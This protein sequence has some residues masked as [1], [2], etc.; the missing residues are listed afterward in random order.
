MLSRRSF[1]QLVGASVAA[2]T[3]RPN[4]SLFA[5]ED[6]FY[7]GR[8]LT[9]LP[10]YYSRNLNAKPTANLWPDAITPIL[11]HD[12]EWYQVPSGWVRREGLQPILP[13]DAKAYE[14][15]GAV[16]F[17]AEVAAPVAPVRAFCAA[18]APLVARIGHGGV[19]RVID[20][21]PGEPNGWYGI[22]DQQGEL[23]GWTQGVFWRP[24]NAEKNIGDDHR[25]S[26]DRERGLMSAYEGTKVVLEVPFS[27]GSGLQ[28]GNFATQYGVIGGVSW[29]A[30]KRYEGIGWQTLF[31]E[32]QMIG[33]VYWHNQ[34][35]H[36]IH[37]GPAVQTTPL[38][39]RWLYG[40]LGE[41]AHIVVK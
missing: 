4:F 35:G 10:I 25:L 14:F 24:V 5:A 23:L 36:P 1:L 22:A 21:L 34:F 6:K 32:G 3:L 30:N 33:G 18:D 20:A 19:S 17:W 9:T 41:E 13:Y 7:Q 2:S 39:A 29:Q 27:A 31:G 16:P 11:S 40:W 15:V 28:A 8:A 12:D 37:D 26:V 38:V